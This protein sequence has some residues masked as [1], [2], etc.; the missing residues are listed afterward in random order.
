MNKNDSEAQR[1]TARDWDPT[2]LPHARLDDLLSE[3]LDQ[4]AEAETRLPRASLTQRIEQICRHAPAS[5]PVESHGFA[6]VVPRHLGVYEIV[7]PLGSGGMGEVYLARHTVLNRNV[8]LKVLRRERAATPRTIERF[9]REMQALAALS[10]PHVV[11][12]YDGN[13]QDGMV[14][15][16]MELVDGIDLKQLSQDQPHLSNRF[17]CELIRQTA[18]GLAAIHDAGIVHRDVKPSNIMLTR[19]GTVKLLDLGLARLVDQGSD[20]TGPLCVIGTERFMSPEQLLGFPDIDCRTDIYS[21]GRTLE[22]LLHW[23]VLPQNDSRVS[24]RKKNDARLVALIQDMVAE[25]R[26]MRISSAALVAQRITEFCR[27]VSRSDLAATAFLSS[28]PQGLDSNTV[29]TRDARSWIHGLTSLELFRWLA[30]FC[31]AIAALTVVIRLQY[32][33]VSPQSDDLVPQRSEVFSETVTEPQETR[34]DDSTVL[35]SLSSGL[36]G[37]AGKVSYTRERRFAECV[38][39]QKGTVTVNMQ[40]SGRWIGKRIERVE[41][42]P[43]TDFLIQVIELPK[44]ALSDQDRTL[45]GQLRAVEGLHLYDPRTSD[46]DIRSLNPSWPVK[47]LYV[48]GQ[49]VSDHGVAAL[50][51]WRNSLLVLD[52]AHSQVTDK[53]IAWLKSFPLLRGLTLTNTRISDESLV[54]LTQF[55][56][57]VSLDISGT[58]ITAVGLRR[59]PECL[60]LTKLKLRELPVDDAV[61]DALSK[62][63]LVE[64][65]L[66]GTSVTEEAVLRF[67]E[68]HPGCD[69]RRE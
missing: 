10:H 34:E 12:A 54:H 65:D 44:G 5:Q 36:P 63:P 69:V 52:L 32:N 57:L 51:S 58:S 6:D 17:C 31:V 38:L 19:D 7:R 39:Q 47:W 45:L 61:L 16:V 35:K 50:E 43:K 49:E 21:L 62:L 15:L 60:Q 1:A 53:S 37:D 13:V 64:L 26:D 67:R 59:L 41:D 22:R 2:T 56:S 11:S 18:L 29:A 68:S 66:R 25:D 14:Y 40:T 20:L 28:N 3:F 24:L 8:A 42:L 30:G 9:Q 48:P 46:A 27:G 4:T 23:D 55:P 33:R